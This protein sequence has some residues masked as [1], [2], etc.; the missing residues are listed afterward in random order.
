MFDYSF[1]YTDL[2]YYLLLVVRM[3]CFIYVAPFFSDRD[4][5]RRVKSGLSLMLAYIVYHS[6]NPHEMVTYSTVIGYSTLVLKEA[7]AGLMIG[8]GANICTQI[9]QMAGKIADME[10]GLSMVQLMDPMT[11]ESTGFTGTLYQYAVMLIMFATNLHHY[12]LRAFIESYR[13]IPVGGELFRSDTIVRAVVRFM[14]DYIAISFSFCLPIVASMLILNAVLGILAKTAPQVNLFTVGM[15]LKILTGLS[16][17]FITIG[18]LPSVSE[19]IFN[20][21]KAMMTVMIES[22]T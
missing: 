15:Q 13:L 17:L 21:M 6:V 1:S 12:V 10:I 9:V 3:S 11:R 2:E 5:P 22:M 4:V 18:V 16:I 20:E 19:Y 8:Y 7:L 14:G